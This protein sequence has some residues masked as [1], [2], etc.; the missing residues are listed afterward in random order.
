MARRGV[1]LG[2][3]MGCDEMTTHERAMANDDEGRMM[4]GARDAEWGCVA[5]EGVVR[6]GAIG[7]KVEEAPLI[8][9]GRKKNKHKRN[10]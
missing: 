2:D 5:G 1:G 3:G 10:T 6:R 9:P 7:E 8:P 4:T